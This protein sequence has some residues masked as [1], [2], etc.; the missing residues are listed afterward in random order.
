M[1]FVPAVTWMPTSQAETV[2]AVL[3]TVMEPMVLL[4]MATVPLL[5]EPMPKLVPLLNAVVTEM[6]PVPVPLPMVLPVT[7]PMF[8]LPACT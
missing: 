6:E 8:T 5:V 3:F 1:V 4:A 2:V 7:V